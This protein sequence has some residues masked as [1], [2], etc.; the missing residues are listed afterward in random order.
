MT[1][2][3]KPNAIHMAEQDDSSNK[4]QDCNK[5]QPLSKTCVCVIVIAAAAAA[6]VT[7]L[8]VVVVDDDDDDD[9]VLS[10]YLSTNI[11]VYSMHIQQN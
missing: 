11:Q 4:W 10:K 9:H 8:V 6:S 2:P 3:W 1:F 5:C 7:I